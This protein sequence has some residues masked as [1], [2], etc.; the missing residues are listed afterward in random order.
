[1]K[2]G[3]DISPGFCAIPSPTPSIS[4]VAMGDTRRMVV[5]LN[6]NIG[7]SPFNFHG[8]GPRPVFRPKY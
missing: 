4:L 3:G 7:V 8:S 6:T 5:L 1:M 2:A